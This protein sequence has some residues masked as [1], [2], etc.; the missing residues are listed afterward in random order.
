MCQ[1]SFRV[2]ESWSCVDPVYLGLGGN[3]SCVSTLD[4]VVVCQPWIMWLCVNTRS[5]P[6]LINSFLGWEFRINSLSN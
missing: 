5:C 4:R 1:P 2:V 3:P 6:L